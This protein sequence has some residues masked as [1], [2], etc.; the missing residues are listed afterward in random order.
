MC[1]E[2]AIEF[3]EGSINQQSYKPGEEF[4]VILKVKMR[5]DVDLGFSYSVV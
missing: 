3:T 2:E 1:D 5:S 4:N